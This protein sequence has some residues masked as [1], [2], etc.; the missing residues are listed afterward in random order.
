MHIKTIMQHSTCFGKAAMA[1]FLVACAANGSFASVRSSVFDDVKVWYRGALAAES[2]Y[3]NGPEGTFANNSG[4]ISKSFKSITCASDSDN[5]L[6]KLQWSWG[7]GAETTLD[8]APV[9]C[10]YAGCTLSGVTYA[11]YPIPTKTNGWAEVT[12]NNETTS[13]PVLSHWKGPEYL[14]SGNWATG[15]ITTYTMIL[16]LRLDTPLNNC[17][18]SGSGEGFSV[19][20]QTPNYSWN[21][22]TGFRITFNGP[23]LGTYRC[24][25]IDFGNNRTDLNNAAV[26]YGNW[27][28]IAVAVNGQ[29]VTLAA[30]AQGESA[31]A[32]DW[33][34]VALSNGE[35]PALPAS[36]N[37]FVFFGPE[38]SGG[39]T[40][41]W[42]NGVKCAQYNSAEDCRRTQ[43][44]R[45]AVHQIAFWDRALSADEIRE[46]WGE[47]RPNLVSV[48]MEG[49]GTADFAATANVV[50]N[51]GPWQ[52]LDPT[53]TAQN[54]SATISFDCPALWSG[55]S[56]WL[57]VAGAGAGR[58]AATI[59]GTPVGECAVAASG[60]GHVFV[61]TNVIVSGANTLVITRTDGS[62]VLDAVRLGGSWRFGE[63]INSF[64]NA[65]STIDRFVFHPA[66][67]ND[68]FHDRTLK[69]SSLGETQLHFFVPEDMVGKFRGVFTTRVQ[70]TGGSTFNFG[71]SANGADLGTYGLKGVNNYEIKIPVENI[72]AGWNSFAWIRQAGWA[73]IDWHRF[74]LIDAP[75]PFVI[76][77]R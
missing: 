45:G 43:C 67:G 63:N 35:N 24:P 31:N 58:V 50:T 36:G 55:Q 23:T 61:P 8:N 27:I 48:G 65:P 60:V 2:Y 57:R 77:L 73:N 70:N 64:A 12:I 32:I 49:N 42:T 59:N 69:N 46:A 51:G 25:R 37:T 66:G 4:K 17:S 75:R 71:F 10:P 9:V 33:K 6:N 22:K 13:Q 68:K 1:A 40:A 14:G 38:I 20:A 3:S 54:P 19:F 47:G 52:R 15:G 28:D 29:S 16:R 41:V 74:D 56:Q 72:A 11:N 53:L 76:T 62:P 30:C 44:F 21:A 18:G 26:P 5:A 34:T 39:Y 7:W